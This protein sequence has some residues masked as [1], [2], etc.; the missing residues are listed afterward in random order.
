M[1]ECS[2]AYTLF[3]RFIFWF[4]R[5][6]AGLQYPSRSDDALVHDMVPAFERNAHTDGEAWF[7]FVSRIAPL[8]AQFSHAY[9][10]V[11]AWHL[12][13][14]ELRYH[15]LSDSNGCI[16]YSSLV[17]HETM[18]L[19]YETVPD[20]EVQVSRYAKASRSLRARVDIFHLLDLVCVD[21]MSKGE[22]TQSSSFP[23]AHTSE[24]MCSSRMHSPPLIARPESLYY[25]GFAS[26][27]HWLHS[28]SMYN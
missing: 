10:D 7:S 20:F 1:A 18:I 22:R 17:S 19:L 3:P 11:E 21:V 13:L 23:R 6:Y 15:R 26:A 25:S 16:P 28:V 9:L 5:L 4:R 27:Q 14:F 24:V 2:L 8:S 12:L